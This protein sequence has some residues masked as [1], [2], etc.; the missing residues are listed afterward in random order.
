M[1]EIVKHVAAEPGPAVLWSFMCEEPFPQ[2][3]HAG[4]EQDL[5]HAEMNFFPILKNILSIH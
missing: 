5:M 4:G 3:Q 2:W 1:L